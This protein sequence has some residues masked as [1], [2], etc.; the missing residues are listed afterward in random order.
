MKP[1]VDAPTSRQSRPVTSIP[2]ASSAFA[3]LCPARETYGGGASTSQL[4][5][6][7]ELLARL[8][9]P[10]HAAGHD[11]RLRLRARLREPA[12]DEQDVKPPLGAHAAS[13]RIADDGEDEVGA[14]ERREHGDDA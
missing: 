1:P 11:E 8:R 3:S 7:V 12:L 13:H 6:L 14:R 2:N 10:G 5:R 4:D 9:V